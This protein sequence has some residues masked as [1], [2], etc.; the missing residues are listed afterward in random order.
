MKRIFLLC[1]FAIGTCLGSAQVLIT[2][3]PHQEGYFTLDDLWRVNVISASPH[4]IQVQLEMQLENAQHQLIL[5]ALSPVFSVQQGSNRPIINPAFAQTQ[6][7]PHQAAGVLRNTGRLPYGIYIVCYQVLEAG[8]SKVIGQYCQEET[9]KPFSPPELISPYN[10]EEL[11]STFPIL[12]WKPPFPPGSTPFEYTLQVVE[13]KEG[14]QALDA[15]ERNTPLLSRRS[16]FVTSMPYPA[17]AWPLKI[18]KQ[19][20][21]QVTARSGNFDLGAT[22]VWTFK[23]LEPEE[24]LASSTPAI[25]RELKLAPAGSYNPVTQQIH[26]MY[27]NR[28]G[29]PSLQYGAIP[30]TGVTNAYLLIYPVGNYLSPIT[31]TLTKTLLLGTNRVSINL[32]GISG[33]TDGKDYILVIRDPNGKEYYMEFTYND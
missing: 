11:Y 25:Y 21:W 9:S 12:S 6:F 22:E 14:Q 16:I 10:G 28:Y 24:R 5:S 29:A 15:L 19:Y 26:F 18:G 32:H 8:S 20:A 31:M 13:V 33:I 7:G 27:P 17:D 23:I 30:N 3:V 1:L 2:P 4:A